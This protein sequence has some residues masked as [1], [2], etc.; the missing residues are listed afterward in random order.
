MTR[1]LH[2]NRCPFRWKTLQQGETASVAPAISPCSLLRQ[3]IAQAAMLPTHARASPRPLS[4]V[5]ASTDRM[6][7]RGPRRKRLDGR[8]RG[9][10]HN[11][12]RVQYLRVPLEPSHKLWMTHQSTSP[13]SC[14]SFDQLA[15]TTDSNMPCNQ[16]VAELRACCLWDSVLHSL[17]CVPNSEIVLNVTFACNDIQS[18]GAS[19]LDFVE[20][21]IHRFDGR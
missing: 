16:T 12:R 18:L 20:K 19:L 21:L 15:S 5:S 10:D 9:S 3:P 1:F 13:L 17:S 2:A 4:I 7:H 6:R 8:F 14:T 11:N